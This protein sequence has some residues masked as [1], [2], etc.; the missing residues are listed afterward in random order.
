MLHILIALEDGWHLE[1]LLNL[2]LLK[3]VLVEDFLHLEGLQKLTRRLE[4][5]DRGVFWVLLPGVVVVLHALLLLREDEG[6][7]IG[8]FFSVTQISREMFKF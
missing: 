2:Q 7:E 5:L 4:L 3:V 8:S 1:L 6:L